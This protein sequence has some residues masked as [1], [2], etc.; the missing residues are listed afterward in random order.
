[1]LAKI[2]R[3]KRKK[4]FE[5]VFRKGKRFNA[6]HVGFKALENGLKTSRFG[7]VVG[8]RISK[9]A[10]TRNKVR[11]R[12]QEAVKKVLPG[13]KKNVDG[14]FIGMP[15]CEEYDFRAIEAIIQRLLKQANILQV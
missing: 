7:F 12:M 5:L 3:L 8:K 10:V 2:N 4:D 15:G 14:V 6:G 9:K 11:R 13:M 1:M